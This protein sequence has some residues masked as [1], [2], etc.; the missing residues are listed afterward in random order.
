MKNVKIQIDH[1]DKSGEDEVHNQ[2]NIIYLEKE[3]VDNVLH[4]RSTPPKT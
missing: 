4:R 1:D 2:I 3:T